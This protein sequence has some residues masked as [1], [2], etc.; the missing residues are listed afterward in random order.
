MNVP[1]FLDFQ[2]TKG[3]ESALSRSMRNSAAATTYNL[4]YHLP[5]R[6]SFTAIIR[7]SCICQESQCDLLEQ[8]VRFDPNKR[9]SAYQALRHPYL[10][11]L[12]D[13]DAAGFALL[14]GSPFTFLITWMDAATHRHLGWAGCWKSCGLELW[15]GNWS[16]WFAAAWL[17]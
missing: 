13:E 7:T 14:L 10:D 11:D 6:H 16:R 4:H 1:R 5:S 3:L 2:C 9:P 8:L 15:W 12:H 17:E